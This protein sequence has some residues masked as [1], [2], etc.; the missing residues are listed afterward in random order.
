MGLAFAAQAKGE[1]TVALAFVGDGATSEGDFHEALNFAAVFHLPVVFF[2]QNNQYAISVP[3]SRQT[4]APSLAHKAV[5]YGMPGVLVDGNDVAAVL[6]VVGEA[7]RR[8]REGRGRRSS[9]RRRT[10]STPTPT[11]TTPPG[12]ARTRRSPAG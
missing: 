6:S 12:T 9:R 5:G 8:A 11:P 4:A 10:G 7:A 1:D 3:V 2:V